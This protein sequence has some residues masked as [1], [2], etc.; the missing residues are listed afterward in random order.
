L[1]NFERQTNFGGHLK[2]KKSWT[3]SKKFGVLYSSFYYFVGFTTRIQLRRYRES[4]LLLE[5][6]FELYYNEKKQDSIPEVGGFLG[7]VNG[8]ILILKNMADNFRVK[9]HNSKRKQ[10]KSESGRLS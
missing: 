7:L 6:L 4:V 1:L 2:L 5:K 10:D 9:L 8:F 3:K